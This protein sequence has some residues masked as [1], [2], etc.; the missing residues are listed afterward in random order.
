MTSEANFEEHHKKDYKIKK[1]YENNGEK[2]Q[3]EEVP[4]ND[5]AITN[6][7]FPNYRVLSPIH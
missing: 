1:N 3:N 7:G 6:S 4:R 2:L 5:S